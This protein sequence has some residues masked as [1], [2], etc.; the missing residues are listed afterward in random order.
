MSSKDST[1]VSREHNAKEGK[2]P[3]PSRKPLL[4]GK[5]AGPNVRT[6]WL[7]WKP[8]T[9]RLRNRGAKEENAHLKAE[10][11][12]VSALTNKLLTSPRVNLMIGQRSMSNGNPIGINFD[13]PTTMDRH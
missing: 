9:V 3:T 8:H 1:R 6:M 7:P 11:D 13:T 4:G 12:R 2:R 10:I 5:L